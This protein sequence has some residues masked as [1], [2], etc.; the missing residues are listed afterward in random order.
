MGDILSAST[1]MQLQNTAIDSGANF[2]IGAATSPF[3]P[4]FDANQAGA[5]SV[6]GGAIGVAA[7]AA[8][9]VGSGL[10]TAL[11][12]ANIVSEGV[13]KL[14][15]K[16]TAYVT[17]CTVKL[18]DI[19]TAYFTYVTQEKIKEGLKGK[20][21][22]EQLMKMLNSDAEKEAEKANE[23]SKKQS[24][25][26]TKQE[27]ANKVKKVTATVTQALT[28]ATKEL[29]T[30]ASYVQQ[31]PEWMSYQVEKYSDLIAY[32]TYGYLTAVVEAFDETKKDW[33]YSLADKTATIAVDDQFR[34]MVA[35]QK[36]NLEKI[37][38]TKQ[39]TIT[40]AKAL[41]AKALMK[42]KG[43]LGG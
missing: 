3:S 30:I 14:S 9:I 28:K 41:V 42:I 4:S 8:N 36:V 12:S 32:Q 39:K 25:E 17:E 38:R 31:G 6:V 1:I 34:M 33:A 27:S 16:L 15:E 37:E 22:M 19:P 2:L 7:G 20:A 24:E 11:L 5:M 29:Q 13:T 10:N 43:L 35:K 23:E 21:S 26:Q 18:M 40:K